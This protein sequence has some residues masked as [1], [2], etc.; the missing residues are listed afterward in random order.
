MRLVKRAL[1]TI[2]ILLS[3]S[4]LTCCA[5]S[6]TG[7]GTFRSASWVYEFVRY[8]NIPYLPTKNTIRNINAVIG[9]VKYYS[10]NELDDSNKNF[11]SNCYKKGA[12]LYSI[13]GI[14]VSDAIAVKVSANKY[15]KLVNIKNTS[16]R[17]LI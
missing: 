5:K 13:K 17:T 6:S 2:F 1:F 7:S 14:R 3:L 8:N 15:V 12:I 4:G 16:L 11:F 9:Q 10:L